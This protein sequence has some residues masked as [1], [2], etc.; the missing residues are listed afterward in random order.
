MKSLASKPNR[1]RF[2]NDGSHTRRQQEYEENN[3]PYY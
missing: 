2:N 3:A 1:E